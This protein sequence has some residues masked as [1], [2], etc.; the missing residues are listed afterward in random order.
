MKPD[1]VAAVSLSESDF[2]GANM[3][4]PAR[5]L[6]GFALGIA[7]ALAPAF[8]QDEPPAQVRATIERQLDAF[9]HDD[10][11]AAY[12]LAAPGI[13]ALFP[14]SGRFMAMV[15]EKYPAV[16]RHRSAEFG[17][18]SVEGEEARQSVTFVDGDNAV[19]KAVYALSRQA[20]GAWRITG[21]VMAKSGDSAI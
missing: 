2:A 11:E 20:D 16:Y 14:D 15:R 8:A 7:F 10:A 6:I 1:A 3:R 13:K 21:C 9:A 17:A 18:A 12:A 19:W 5:L 4:D